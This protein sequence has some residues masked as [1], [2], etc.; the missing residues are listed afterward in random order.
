MN[1]NRR[2][3]FSFCRCLK[4]HHIK[5]RP[6]NAKISLQFDR[7]KSFI[8]NKL[9]SILWNKFSSGNFVG[10]CFFWATK[11]DDAYHSR[12]YGRMFF[13]CFKILCS[14]LLWPSQNWRHIL[15]DL[16]N[17]S[18]ANFSPFIDQ[19]WNLRI[20]FLFKRSWSVGFLCSLAVSCVIHIDSLMWLV[21]CCC[22]L[23]F[24]HFFLQT[25]VK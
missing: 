13:N 19:I 25:I 1:F 9:A 8:E 21:L 22:C 7:F 10:C 4:N 24:Q 23:F 3:W 5:R 16:R 14:F 6:N 18:M 11:I 15:F 17:K 12:V 20:F 2:I